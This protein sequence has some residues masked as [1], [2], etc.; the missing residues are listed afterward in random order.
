[1]ELE[2][3]MALI[4]LFRQTVFFTYYGKELIAFAEQ[5]RSRD[6]RELNARNCIDM[7]AALF[8][9]PGGAEYGRCLYGLTYCTSGC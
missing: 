6:S 2:S 8:Q 7:S 3:Y 5:S 1:M 9:P 4:R